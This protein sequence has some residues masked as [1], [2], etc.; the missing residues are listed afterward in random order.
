MA[1]TR[2]N[3]TG[4]TEETRN[5]FHPGDIIAAIKFDVTKPEFYNVLSSCLY[6][7]SGILGMLELICHV[8]GE[9]REC[10]Q[11]FIDVVV[12]ND[13]G[14][15]AYVRSL[16]E[17]RLDIISRVLAV[18]E[19]LRK[20]FPDLA[21]FADTLPLGA[22]SKIAKIESTFGP[23]VSVSPMGLTKAELAERL[24]AMRK[25]AFP[26]TISPTSLNG[27]LYSQAPRQ[28]EAANNRCRCLTQ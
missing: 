15:H 7:P 22:E 19:D 11:R 2:S 8:F 5:Q 27:G 17:Y 12:R 9:G 10:C 14:T 20:T 6:S 24:S 13:S 28:D 3:T 1:A 21:Q 23:V 4:W 18:Q 16:A 26:E 25:I